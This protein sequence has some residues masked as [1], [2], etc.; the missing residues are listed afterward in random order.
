[1][2]TGFESLE[3]QSSSETMFLKSKISNNHSISGLPLFVATTYATEN[4]ENILRSTLIKYHVRKPQDQTTMEKRHVFEGGTIK[5]LLVCFLRW[6]G[7]GGGGQ[8]FLSW[9]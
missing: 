2:H 5:V 7:G 9:Q 1:M 6:G 8:W 4:K 3:N